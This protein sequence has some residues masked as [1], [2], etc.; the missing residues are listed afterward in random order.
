M[1]AFMIYVPMSTLDEICVGVTRHPNI[2]RNEAAFPANG[3][4]D[5]MRAFLV[6]EPILKNVYQFY[7]LVILDR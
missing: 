4:K 3:F 7:G 5:K 1:N 2:A 6:L